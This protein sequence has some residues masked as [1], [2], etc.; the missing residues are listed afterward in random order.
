MATR[1][2]SARGADGGSGSSLNTAT[3]IS[4]NAGDG[5]M[6]FGQHDGA[7]T[8]QTFSDNAAG[9]SNV[10]TSRDTAA[11]DTSVAQIACATAIA[12]ASETLTFTQA[13]A[14]ARSFREVLVF[15]GRPGA[16]NALVY[17]AATGSNGDNTA[18]STGALT[19]AGQNGFAAFSVIPYSVVSYTPG[20]GWTEELEPGNNLYPY[21]AYRLLTNET[22]I[23]G[24]AT[25]SPSAQWAAVVAAFREEASGGGQTTA[26]LIIN[27]IRNRAG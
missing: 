21:L 5:I 1:V 7:L 17:D 3:T 26:S 22:S 4:V 19:V 6:I 9:G 12:K 27:V 11:I 20:A 14:A 10:Y 24:N 16:G 13:L 25:M 15:V 23:T 2:G 18:P 8:A